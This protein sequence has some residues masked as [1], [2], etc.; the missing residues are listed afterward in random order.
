[1]ERISLQFGEVANNSLVHLW[2]YFA[3]EGVENE[4][5]KKKLFG[6]SVKPKTLIYSD[7]IG[8]KGI[9]KEGSV[10]DEATFSAADSASSVINQKTG[11]WTDYNFGTEFSESSYRELD[12]FDPAKNFLSSFYDSKAKSTFLE[13]FEDDVRKL[14][15]SCDW[16]DGFNFVTEG[17]GSIGASTLHSLEHLNDEYTKA[18]KIV[19]SFS[20]RIKISSIESINWENCDKFDGEDVGKALKFAL[21][22]NSINDQ[23]VT[24]IPVGNLSESLFASNQTFGLNLQIPREASRLFSSIIYD[25]FGQQSVPGRGNFASLIAST[26]NNNKE[27][28]IN[29]TTCQKS[30]GLN[31][32]TWR[33][34]PIVL[35]DLNYKFDQIDLVAFADFNAKSFAS[36]AAEKFLEIT[37]G[38]RRIWQLLES[39][40]VAHELAAGDYYEELRETL[41]QIKD[42]SDEPD[43]LD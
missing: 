32:S 33:K 35:D 34:S 41:Y 29:F 16:L 6:L 7:K 8:L 37:N 36:T 12:Q 4:E 27:D 21:N 19:L 22:F 23:N 10:L 9:I 11:R 25:L 39:T 43:L 40:G 28:S 20:E 42:L 2:N 18:S 30:P 17:C 3:F 1:M 24:F 14:A 5:I 13:D 26:P 31:L 15:E 38:P